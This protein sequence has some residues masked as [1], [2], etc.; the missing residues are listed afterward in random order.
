MAGAG[1]DAAMVRLV[2][3]DFKRRFGKLSYW[4][5]AFAQVGKRLPEFQVVCDGRR[6]RASFALMARVKNYGGDLEIARHADLLGDDLAVILF[7]GPGT[8][9]YLKYFSGVLLNRLDGMKGVT[10][11]RAARVEIRPEASEVDLQVDGEYAGLAPATVS[12]AELCVRLLLPAGFAARREA[13]GQA[14]IPTA[15][16]SD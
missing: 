16:H 12:M 2:S 11:T 10:V 14:C 13:A 3:G 8:F 6:S 15:S 7:E 4:I 9:R 1:L 5:A